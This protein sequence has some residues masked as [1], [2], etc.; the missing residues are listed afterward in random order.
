MKTIKILHIM[1][2]VSVAGSKIHGPARQLAYR[3]P[4]YNPEKFSV[5]LINLREEDPACKLIREAGIEVD[6]LNRGKF[7]LRAFKDIFTILGDW[8]PDLIHVHGYAAFT[9]GRVAG[10]LRKI[11]VVAQ[12]HFVDEELPFYQKIP[13][14]ILRN[15]Q[16]KGLAVSQAV[17]DFMVNDRYMPAADITVLGNGIPTT[18]IRESL[19][20][21]DVS[22]LKKQAGF[23]E[24]C[25][26]I[27]TVGRLTEMKGQIYFL[28][29]AA[30]LMK[31]MP[32][33]KLRFILVGDGPLAEELCTSARNLNIEAY[34]HF[35]GYQEDVIQWYKLM[36]YGVVSS[37]FG[38][39]FCSVGIEILSADVP[40]VITDLPC[41]EGIYVPDQNVIQIPGRDSKAM[42]EALR[43]LMQDDALRNR[44]IE[45][46]RQTANDYDMVTIAAAYEA[47]YENML[48]N[49]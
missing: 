15:Q 46:G 36:D 22:D 42:A 4:F 19:A 47:F 34:V 32:D 7:D 33:K 41:F 14:F 30:E 25:I 31:Q 29:A 11:P 18:R 21:C 20:S 39:G 16:K 48:T 1:D 13:D 27:G 40:L 8:H 12:E 24:D 49:P 44:L 6:S 17:K 28:Q 5:R 38:E 26:V 23:P 45:G 37:I 10:K 3:I 2:K 35:T 9:F 43:S